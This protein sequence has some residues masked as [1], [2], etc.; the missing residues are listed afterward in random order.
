MGQKSFNVYP[1]FDYVHK[2]DV[3]MADIRQQLLPNRRLRMQWSRLKVIR[4][5][6]SKITQKSESR[7]TGHHARG[8]QGANERLGSLKNITPRRLYSLADSNCIAQLSPKNK[9]SN[10]REQGKNGQR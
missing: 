9:G 1:L 3:L 2:I 7:I 4:I 5:P 8:S 6:K 10:L